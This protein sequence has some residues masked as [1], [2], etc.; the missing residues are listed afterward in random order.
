MKLNSEEGKF[1]R[2]TCLRNNNRNK[3]SIFYKF[4]IDDG[5]SYIKIKLID[6]F[7]LMVNDLISDD[8]K[9]EQLNNVHIFLH[10][11]KLQFN[12]RNLKKI[13][14][15]C[16]YYPGNYELDIDL[17][18]RNNLDEGEKISIFKE[19]KNNINDYICKEKDLEE[20]QS[21]Y[22]DI[23]FFILTGPHKSGTTLLEAIVNNNPNTICLHEKRVIE[24]IK[25]NADFLFEPFIARKEQKD[26]CNKN[27]IL[28]DNVNLTK[29]IFQSIGYRTCGDRSPNLLTDELLNEDEIQNIKIVFIKRD[30]IDT[31]LSLFDHEIKGGRDPGFGVDQFNKIH[32]NESC[33][34]WIKNNTIFITNQIK[35]AE[36]I[37]QNK[38]KSILIIDYK[39]LIENK[40]LYIKKIYNY[41]EFKYDD[42]LIQDV[43]NLTSFTSMKKGS[44]TNIGDS[45]GFVNIGN[46]DYQTKMVSPTILKLIE[47]SKWIRNLFKNKLLNTV[48]ESYI[49]FKKI[50]MY[51]CLIS[52]HNLL[53]EKSFCGFF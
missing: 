38:D 14:T 7:S 31:L 32:P 26:G 49:Y 3:N 2:I 46:R 42:E 1:L 22:E 19:N 4:K 53:K 23:S 45:N 18:V 27:I 29:E 51:F 24:N 41:L 36:K 20:Y 15:I 30:L 37:Q 40:E 16:K 52:N 39:R 9:F 12:I 33:L 44:Y 48:K 43:V 10:K 17:L 28:N 25:T 34:N 11:A 5:V 13:L 8:Y 47:D 35:I 6:E 21:N 50:I